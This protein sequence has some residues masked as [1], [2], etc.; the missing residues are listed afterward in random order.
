MDKSQYKYIPTQTE[1]DRIKNIKDEEIDFSDAP[2][3]D[4]SFWASAQ[5][6]SGKSTGKKM[7]SMPYDQHLL[8][9]FQKEAKNKGIEYQSLI[10]SVL[11]SYRNYSQQKS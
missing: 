1:L 7:V 4:D 8:K 3:T 10:H 6:I 11:E 9:W 5:I 2:E